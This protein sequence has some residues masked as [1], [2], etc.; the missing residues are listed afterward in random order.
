MAGAVD[1][2]DSYAH[3]PNP[4]LRAAALALHGGRA[5]AAD[6]SGWQ[7]ARAA[8]H[9]GRHR[10]P[11]LVVHSAR[12]QTVNV[13][14]AR[15]FAASLRAAGYPVDLDVRAGDSH[16]LRTAAV[17]ATADAWVDAVLAGRIS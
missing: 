3:D 17:T 15:R 11:F 7:A 6:P 5:P 8:T 13:R 4:K 16:V 14:T 1:P 2:Y 12:D 10:M 9:L